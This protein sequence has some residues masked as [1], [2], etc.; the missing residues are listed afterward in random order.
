MND[1]NSDKLLAFMIVCAA[2]LAWGLGAAFIGE[3]LDLWSSI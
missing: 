1:D 3:L 2:H